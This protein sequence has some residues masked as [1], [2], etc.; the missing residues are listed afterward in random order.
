MYF[1][2]CV[3]NHQSKLLFG[4]VL[5]YVLGIT[6]DHIVLMFSDCLTWQTLAVGVDHQ[7]LVYD[8]STVAISFAQVRYLTRLIT[9]RVRLYAVA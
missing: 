9:M 2:T 8:Q 5:L 3:I 4:L 6:L 7:R 1:W